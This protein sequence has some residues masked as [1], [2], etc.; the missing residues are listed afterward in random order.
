MKE[1]PT[2]KKC[3]Y[4]NIY[5]QYRTK[6]WLIFLFF[7]KDGL[8]NYMLLNSET[9]NVSNHGYYNTF[10][11]HTV[12]YTRKLYTGSDTRTV[13]NYNCVLK[14]ELNDRKTSFFTL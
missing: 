8:S 14:D 7:L 6:T 13:T 1:N 3:L 11:S 4:I 9:L 2:Q 10:S 5:I 12:F